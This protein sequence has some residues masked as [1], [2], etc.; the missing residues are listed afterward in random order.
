MLLRLVGGYIAD[1]VQ[2]LN[3][4]GYGPSAMAK[5]GLLAAGSSVTAIGM[6]ITVDRAGRGLRTAPQGRADHALHAPAELSRAIRV[7]G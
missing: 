6:P 4:W 5:L 7:T 2:R 1:R 3:G